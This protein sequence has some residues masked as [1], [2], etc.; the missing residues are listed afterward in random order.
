MACIFV[1]LVSLQTGLTL[2][3]CYCREHV[4]GRRCDTC[5]NTAYLN[6]T[7]G[8]C[9]P[10][11]CS[12]AGAVNGSCDASGTCTCKSGFQGRLCDICTPGLTGIACDQCLQMY[13][14]YNASTASCQPCSCA[15]NTGATSNECDSLTGQCRCQPGFV[16]RDCSVCAAT[17][18]TQGPRCIVCRPGYYG[19]NGSL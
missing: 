11:N 7:I 17:A 18:G 16:G 12:S 14:S 2:G 13:W 3:M 19:F 9:S 8:S 1:Y 5:S 4:G 6:T 10:C 15:T